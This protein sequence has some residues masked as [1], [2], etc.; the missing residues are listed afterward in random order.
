MNTADYFKQCE[1]NRELLRDVMVVVPARPADGLCVKLAQMLSLWYGEGTPWNCLEDAMGGFIERTRARIAHDFKNKVGDMNE[2]FLLMIDND[3]E[4]PMNLPYLLARHN[5][6]IVGSCAMSVNPRGHGMLCFT[7]EDCNGDSRFVEIPYSRKIPATG[8]AKVT[9]VGT[10]AMLIRRD[11]IDSFTFEEGDIP[12]FI[13][14]QFRSAGFGN[15][16]VMKGEDISFCDQVRKKGF[17]I[18]VDMEAHCGHRKMMRLK[19]EEECRDPSMRVD[20][21]VLPPEG[22]MVTK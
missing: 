20:D 14:E 2:K 7:K 13:P 6:P 10:G 19:W 9:H 4:P 21:W 1:E 11:V 16:Q 5:K 15:G 18:H 22:M 8:L 3:I 12:F 17:D